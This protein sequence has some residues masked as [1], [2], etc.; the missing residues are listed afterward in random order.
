MASRGWGIGF[1]LLLGACGP[2]SCGCH[3]ARRYA[4]LPDGPSAAPPTAA[5][6]ASPPATDNERQLA[7]RLRATVA[8]FAVEVGERNV[9]Q[10]WNLATATDDIARGLEK[11]GYEV[12]RQGIVIGGDA[13]VQNVEVHVPGGERG[14]QT[15][16]VGAHFDSHSGTPGA[17][18]D[19]SGVAAVLEL[20]RVFRDAKLKRTVRFAFFTNEEE[21]DFQTEHMGSLVYAKELATQRLEIVGML[22]IDG[23]QGVLPPS[24]PGSE[25]GPADA[26]AGYPTTAD[27]LAIVG[28]ESSRGLLEQVTASM[29]KH[30]TLP[31]VGNVFAP[32]VPFAA[33]SRSVVVLEGRHAR[34]D[35]HRTPR[36]SG[37]RTTHRRRIYRSSWISIEWHAS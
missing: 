12:R 3:A 30:T 15:L 19:A 10:S 9:A 13:V 31:V 20:A 22:N 1:A 37:T 25:R 27:F 35:D 24:A 17:G 5:H 23:I 18:D 29:K 36:R 11:M 16:V 2:A 26:R 28:N 33:A 21:P 34:R 6:A 8:H 32:E 4:P 7:E 14:G